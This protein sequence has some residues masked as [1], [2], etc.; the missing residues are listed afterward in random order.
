MLNQREPLDDTATP[1][2][3]RKSASASKPKAA[4]AAKPA[5]GVEVKKTMAGKKSLAT[6]PPKAQVKAL[7]K[8]PIK[9][10]MAQA[11]TMAQQE[12][13]HN[14]IA[15]LAYLLWES[16]GCVGGSPDD[17]WLKAEALLRS[18]ST[19]VS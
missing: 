19:A 16:R 1:V 13:A 8:A 9:A 6:E 18:G 2:K 10:K 4:K 3:P 11:P 5:A 7:S 14:D 12:I 17:D 15:I